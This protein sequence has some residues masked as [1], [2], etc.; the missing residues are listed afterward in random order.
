MS[1]ENIKRK[2]KSK[3]STLKIGKLEINRVEIVFAI[4]LI[5]D[6]I[7]YFALS[8]IINTVLIFLCVMTLAL[9]LT[10]LLGIIFEKKNKRAKYIEKMLETTVI[11]HILIVGILLG[12]ICRCGYHYFYIVPVIICEL[13]EIIF[14]HIFVFNYKGQKNIKYVLIYFLILNFVYVLFLVLSKV[15]MQSIHDKMFLA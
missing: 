7:A 11:I 12:Q 8:R 1:E 10:Y 15:N 3:K 5:L 4:L 13:L 2:K 14:Y 6:I 9:F